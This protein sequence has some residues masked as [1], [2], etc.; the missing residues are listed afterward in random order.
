[1]SPLIKI[2]Y[3][4]AASKYTRIVQM[5]PVCIQPSQ[6]ILKKSHVFGWGRHIKAA[7]LQQPRTSL[8]RDSWVSITLSYRLDGWG[9]IPSGGKRFFSQRHLYRLWG[10]ASVLYSG[11]Q[12]LFPRGR[13]A[14]AQKFTT[15]L[16]IAK[17]KNVGSPVCL[18]GIVLKHRDKFTLL[19]FTQNNP[20]MGFLRY[21]MT[22][23]LCI[24]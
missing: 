13:R 16:F 11:Y 9:S 3:L 7:L 5:K 10:P 19:S 22:T 14:K 24:I 8:K 6:E 12:W 1:M 20:C 21:V 23:D 15:N 17:I 2:L 18:H 4:C